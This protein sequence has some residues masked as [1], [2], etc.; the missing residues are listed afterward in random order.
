MRDLCYDT[1]ENILVTVTTIIIVFVRQ[2]VRAALGWRRS[3]SLSHHRYLPPTPAELQAP[4]LFL[5]V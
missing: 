5:W 2:R 1:L 4:C 3:I